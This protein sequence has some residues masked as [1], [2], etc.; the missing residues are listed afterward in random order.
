MA[1][2][3]AH[4]RFAASS[5]PTLDVEQRLLA[6]E[7][8]LAAIEALQQTHHQVLALLKETLQEHAADTGNAPYRLSVLEDVTRGLTQVVEV[9]YAA[10]MALAQGRR[11]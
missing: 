11:L 7:G 2:R 10:V 6:M 3:D 8:R 1:E 4:G 5:E 9:T